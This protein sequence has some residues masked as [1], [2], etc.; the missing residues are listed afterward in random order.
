[1]SGAMWAKRERRKEVSKERKF[2]SFLTQV[3]NST[4][5]TLFFSKQQKQTQPSSYIY[6]ISD[7]RVIWEFD[8]NAKTERAVY[9]A[10]PFLPAGNANAF[11]V[12]SFSL[13]VSRRGRRNVKTKTHSLLS[14]FLSS[15]R[16]LASSAS[17]SS[18]ALASSTSL[19]LIF[20]HSHTLA[21]KPPKNKISTTPSATTFS[22]WIRRGSSG[23]GIG[24]RKFRKSRRRPRRS[25]CR[26][27]RSLRMPC[28][29]RAATG[30]SARQTRSLRHKLS[31]KWN[32]R[33]AQELP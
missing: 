19:L 1:M 33:T 14:F 3:N 20:S 28:F 32:S 16:S 25:V 26:A 7:D 2:D 24:F 27:S 12:R 13:A 23:T 10:D 5:P 21:R 11:A 31:S 29:S 6:G 8:V 9:N 30:S 17:S 15:S 22:F 18:C 4:P